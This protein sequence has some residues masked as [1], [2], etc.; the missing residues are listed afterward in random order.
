MQSPKTFNITV[1]S[2]EMFI[3]AIY[4][5]DS[6]LPIVVGFSMNVFYKYRSEKLS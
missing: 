3:K 2:V 6:N 5:A 4:S 1:V